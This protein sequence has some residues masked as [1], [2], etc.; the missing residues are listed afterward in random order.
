MAT[1]WIRFNGELNR[2]I[3]MANERGV[4]DRPVIHKQLAWC[5]SKV[6]IMRY[7]SMR[8]LTLFLAGHQPGPDAA[9]AELFYSEYHPK[10]TQL[11]MSILGA[12]ELAP[13]VR[14]PRTSFGTDD[15]CALNSSASWVDTFLNTRGRDDL[16]G[17]IGDPTQRPLRNGPRDAEGTSVSVT[18]DEALFLPNVYWSGVL[19]GGVPDSSRKLALID[20]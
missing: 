16:R 19:R 14:K 9:I 18:G 5:Y 15:A 8:T 12:D 10:S 20:A 3:R 4:A 11:A 13:V 17:V 6:Q 1:N 7:L 2:L